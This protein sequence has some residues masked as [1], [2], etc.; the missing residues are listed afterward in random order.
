VATNRA[1][2]DLRM[3][4]GEAAEEAPF[5][6]TRRLAEVIT[7]QVTHVET[8]AG[9]NRRMGW[10]QPLADGLCRVKLR[11]EAVT[12]RVREVE[13]RL[14]NT[15]WETVSRLE[16]TPYIDGTPAGEPLMPK[17]LWSG[18]KLYIVDQPTVRLMR[19]L[20]EELTRPFGEPE[21]MEAVADCIDRDAEFVREYLTANFELDAQAELPPSEKED[22]PKKPEGDESEDEG[23]PDEKETEPE[24]EGE[25]G[26]EP[27]EGE[28]EELPAGGEEGEPEPEKPKAPSFMDRYARGRGFRWHEMERCYTHAS[29]A[30]IEKGEAPFN[31]HEH[32]DGAGVTKRLFVVEESLT[33]GVEI[34]YELWRLMEIN[35]DSIALVLSAEE[36]EPIEWSASELQKL[37]A[38]GQLHLHQSR[39]ILKETIS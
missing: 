32:A 33:R 10:L 27:E 34:P 21:I 11:D 36:G 6:V 39:F 31:W 20:K 30:W 4:Q 26:E 19:E 16:V 18:T 8:M 24:D 5:T 3:L 2:A 12:A 1:T 22:E 25:E 13:R 23:E 35:P 38:N 29:G 14:L 9:R 15:T 37:K 7:M 28:E 17:V